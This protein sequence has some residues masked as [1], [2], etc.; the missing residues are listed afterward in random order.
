MECWQKTTLGWIGGQA[1]QTRP[2]LLVAVLAD[3]TTPAG[4]MRDVVTAW[5]ATLPRT[6]FLIFDRVA[7][8][9]GMESCLTK[10][11]E[12]TGLPPSRLLLVG[13]RDAGTFGLSIALTAPHAGFAGLLA[14]DAVLE[15]M[16]DRAGPA[17]RPKI[18]LIGRNGEG[19][20]DDD[21]FARTIHEL[22]AFGLDV[23]GT[24][25]PDPGW[26]PSSIRIGA[27]YLAELSAAALGVPRTPR[28]LPG[29]LS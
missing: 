27:S 12:E 29:S 6:L 3:E 22:S 10:A 13:V 9:L 1:D 4:V 26:T 8:R 20:S 7:D 15:G 17:W 11:L 25:L 2:E 5:S 18:R 24:L 14:Y 19:R 21:L 16:A 28:P 23:R